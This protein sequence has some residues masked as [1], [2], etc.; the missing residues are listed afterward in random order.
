MAVA[1]TIAKTRFMPF[2]PTV[3]LRGNVVHFHKIFAEI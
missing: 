1:A 3:A 2:I